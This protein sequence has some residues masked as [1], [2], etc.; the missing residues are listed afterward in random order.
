MTGL[1]N[2]KHRPASGGR[3]PVAKNLPSIL[4][5]AALL[6]GMIFAPSSIP[7]SKTLILTEHC[8]S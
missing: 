5:L 8:P 3:R 4:F 6:S 1:F 2:G 7:N